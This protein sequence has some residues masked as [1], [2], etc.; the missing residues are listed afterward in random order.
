MA[1]LLERLLAVKYVGIV[2]G[3]GIE[4][5][6]TQV[7]HRLPNTP[8]LFKKLLIMPTKGAM[9]YTYDG[10]SWQRSY[11]KVL[12]PDEKQKIQEAF[13]K[14]A[15]EVNFLPAKTYGEQLEDREAQFTFSALGQN[16][17]V[18][19][20]KAWDPDVKK[21]QILRTLLETY[22]PEFQIEIGGSTSIDITQKNIDKAFALEKL[23]EYLHISITDMLFV[24]D[25]LFPGGNDSAVLK[26]GVDTIE[27]KD[28]NE[29]KEIIE[30]IIETA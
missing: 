24:G 30:K 11:E 15:K 6:M 21:R 9:M 14:A 8:S 4:Q 17:P 22:I 7:V 2:S 20:K 5:L 19:L 13:A 12:S 26:T 28:Y 27:V 25:A 10:T 23:S 29:T 18:A 16:A 3:G 1:G